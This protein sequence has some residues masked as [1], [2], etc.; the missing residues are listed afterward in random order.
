MVCGWLFHTGA[1][2]V[3]WMDP[4]GYDAYRVECRFDPDQQMPRKPVSDSLNRY[5]SFRQHLPEDVAERVRSDGW[6]L[7]L[8]AEWVDLFVIH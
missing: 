1:P 4:G 3:L 5:G 6:S 7:P 8:L 2:V